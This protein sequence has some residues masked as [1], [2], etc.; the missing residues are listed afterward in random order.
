MAADE[1]VLF[2]G[3]TLGSRLAR[4]MEELSPSARRYVGGEPFLSIREVA[5]KTIIGRPV[6]SGLPVSELEDFGRNVRSILRKLF[7]DERLPE[8]EVRIFIVAASPSEA[9]V[10]EDEEAPAEDNEDLPTP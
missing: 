2:C 7:P 6:Q 4:L 8:S 1:S 3:V 9:A 10:A 5:G